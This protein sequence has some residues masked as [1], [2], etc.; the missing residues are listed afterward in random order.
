MKRLLV[1]FC[2]ALVANAASQAHAQ[3]SDVEFGY[4]GGMIDIEFGPE[5]RVF[6]GEFVVGGLFDR[7]TDDPGWG[8][9]VADGKGIGPGELIGYNVLENLFYWDGTAETTTS[10]FVTFDHFPAVPNNVVSQTGIT[11]PNASFSGSLLNVIDQAAPTGDFHQH[12]DWTLSAGS[13]T[14]AYG[15]LLELE[16]NNA[17]IANSQNF[18]IVWNFGLSDVQFEA[19]VDHFVTTRNLATAAIPEPSSATMLLAIGASALFARR[20]RA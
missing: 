20:R 16:S 5:G 15:V 1:I 11:S 12:V 3:H 6:E 7:T 2:C 13:P 10:A 4:S 19:G 14:G 17:G 8:S 18:G 9:E